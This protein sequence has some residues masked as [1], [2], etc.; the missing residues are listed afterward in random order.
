MHQ[1]FADMTEPAP[2]GYASPTDPAREPLGEEPSGDAKTFNQIVRINIVHN[3]KEAR[4]QLG[5][6]LGIR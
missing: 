1:S 5:C 2:S 6:L 3:R 4:Q